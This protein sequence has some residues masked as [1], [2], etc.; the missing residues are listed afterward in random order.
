MIE[1]S[2]L[3]KAAAGE[4]DAHDTDI[5]QSNDAKKDIFANIRLTLPPNE[6]TAWRDAIKLRQKRAVSEEAR[7]GLE[8]HDALVWAMLAM[9]EGKSSQLDDEE[10]PAATETPANGNVEETA[11]THAHPHD[12][13]EARPPHDPDTGELT[14]PLVVASHYLQP[15]QA[16]ETVLNTVSAADPGPIPDYLRRKARAAA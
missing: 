8:E 9:L 15:A 5:R 14:E 16:A 11:P 2:D 12:A 10:A 7:M 1:H 4:I 3:L 13:R 6:F